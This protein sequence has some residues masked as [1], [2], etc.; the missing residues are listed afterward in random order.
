[1]RAV[2]A[3]IGHGATVLEPPRAKIAE[4]T[5]TAGDLGGDYGVFRDGVVRRR[6]APSD[7]WTAAP[8]SPPPR[9]VSP[10]RRQRVAPPTRGAEGAGAHVRSAPLAAAGLDLRLDRQTGVSASRLLHGC[11]LLPGGRRTLAPARR[12][13]DG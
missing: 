5:D 4:P 13:R 10:R 2:H 8:L 6:R 1:M 9:K 3:R 7:P 12:A 11:S